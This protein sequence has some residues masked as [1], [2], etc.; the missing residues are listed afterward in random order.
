MDAKSLEFNKGDTR[1]ITELTVS[2]D[3]FSPL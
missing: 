1:P 2:K 3:V